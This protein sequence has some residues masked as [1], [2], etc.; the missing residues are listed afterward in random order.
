M[1]QRTNQ[2]VLPTGILAARCAV[3]LIILCIGI[4]GIVTRK[5]LY[6]D[7]SF[8]LLSVITTGTFW[9]MPARELAG[10]IT[11]TPL[12][13]GVFA[14][15]RGIDALAGLYGI[16]LIGVP[17][18]LWGYALFIHLRTSLFWVFVV[19]F[20]WF[21][22]ISGFFTIGEYNVGY[23]VVA[24]AAAI[25]LVSRITAVDAIVL[26]VVAVL[27]TRSYELTAFAGPFLALTC[28][29]R[30]CAAA[31][32]RDAM[33]RTARWLT[34]LSAA[35]FLWGAL[36]AFASILHPRDPAMYAESI[37][38]TRL[39]ISSP[40]MYAISLTL[41]ALLASVKR[42][43]L[44]SASIVVASGVGLA[45]GYAMHE[46][47]HVY[48]SLSY[49][50][51]AALVAPMAAGLLLLSVHALFPRLKMWSQFA[52]TRASAALAILLLITL[53]STF[54]S[55][56]AGHARMLQAYRAELVQLPESMP[57]DQTLLGQNKA[58]RRYLWAW[59]NPVMSLL[60][61]DGRRIIEN[62]SDY[63]GWE[64]DLSSVI[65][66]DLLRPFRQESG[67]TVQE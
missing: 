52:E 56:T 65:K 43:P 39:L 46:S 53:G 66:N 32:D 6:A 59:T 27:A 17:F 18:V 28:I 61:G 38:G 11:Q 2:E 15:V 34:A 21:Y 33:D 16:G 50:F 44:W 48:P 19:A 25:L 22:L 63:R 9:L 5:V 14:G 26:L 20:A 47:W 42:F 57:V 10:I 55:D 8:F 40:I 49:E 62:A 37:A 60:L 12:L 31:R 7:G 3:L 64:P 54:V 36:I 58:Y 41:L 35:L 23:S 51:R 30:L 1:I 4:F 67:A 45:A 13:I 24:A 29:G